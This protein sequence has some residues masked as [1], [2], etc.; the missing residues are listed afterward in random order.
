MNSKATRIWLAIAAAL[1]ALVGV[2]QTFRPRTATGPQPLFP[3]LLPAAVASVRVIFPEAPA[4]RA[5]RTNAG[6][7]LTQPIRYPAQSSAIKAL[8]DALQ[9]LTP[10]LRLGAGA[11]NQ[12]S[13]TS[14]KY[15]FVHPL[16]LELRQ[17]PHRWRLL[18]GR[19]TAPGDQ[20]YVRVG[21]RKAVFVVDAGW[22]KYLPR[23]ADNWRDTAL[24]D[25]NVNT[26]N[27]IVITNGPQVVEI[28]RNPTTRLWRMTRPLETWANNGR[29]AKF[30]RHLQAARVAR[31]VTDHPQDLSAYGL[32]PA[33]LDFWLGRGTN[34]VTA[35]FL[36]LDATSTATQVFGR[37]KGW[38]V[39]FTTAASPL[40]YWWAQVNSFRDP[41]LL[42]L[43]APV[44]EIRVRGPDNFVLRRRATND[45]QSVGETF[46]V[47]ARSVRQFIQTLA[48]LRVA[49]FVKDVVTPPDFHRYGLAK[50]A[51]QITLFSAAGR[52]NVVL[53]QLAFGAQQTNGVFVRCAG[54]DSVYA[55]TPE[56]FDRL[57]DAAWQFRQRRIWKFRDDD[58]SRIIIR[59][60]GQTRQ[61]IHLGP[62][63]WSLAAGSQGIIVPPAI[64]E[65]AYQLGHL[66]AAAWVAHD[67]TNAAPY[68]FKPGNLSLTVRLKNGTSHTVNFG[69]T[70]RSETALAAVTLHGERW[71]FVFPPATY[72]LVQSYLA[73]PAEAP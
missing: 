28:R 18:V 31:F 12:I 50:P 37:R 59:Q 20:V 24:V 22:L 57:P 34:V 27:W 36:G 39:V 54:D 19:R 8:L 38:N 63:Q 1:F 32:Q 62:N 6:W 23:S 53:A 66:Y 3:A 56:A 67:V 10:A 51:R 4:I 60:N 26:L 41:H 14:A 33:H 71:V 55:I 40:S 43:T 72:Q 64:E 68:G 5:L 17:G 47:D 9:S 44:S 73:L 29:I 65:T 46:P 69:E 42:E 48:G 45:W 52:T 16:T 11:T 30:L 21:G 61:M 58:V 13:S 15:G 2:L 7:Q 70:I 49:S 35:L 25:V